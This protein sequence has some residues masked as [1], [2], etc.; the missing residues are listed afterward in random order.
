MAQGIGG[1]VKQNAAVGG[2]LGVGLGA[3]EIAG[4]ESKL[5]G[6]ASVLAGILTWKAGLAALF[7]GTF[8]KSK[9]AMSNLIKESGS[10]EAALRRIG[11]AAEDAG[12]AYAKAKDKMKAGAGAAW[13]ESEITNTKNMTRAVE[14]MTPAVTAASNEWAKISGGLST[15]KS[16]MTKAAAE[17]GVLGSAIN[18]VSQS[19]GALAIGLSAIAGVALVKWLFELSSAAGASA[20]WIF[21]MEAATSGAVS[22]LAKF[23]YY[24]LRVVQVLARW[25]GIGIIVSGILAVGGAIHSQIKAWD[26]AGKAANRMLDAALDSTRAIAAQISMIKTAEDQAKA[27]ASALDEL[28]KAQQQ[29]LAVKSSGKSKDSQ[30]MQAAETAKVMAEKAVKRAAAATPTEG[31]GSGTEPA[32]L[33]ARIARAQSDAALEDR[34]ANASEEAKPDLLREKARIAAERAATGASEV[35]GRSGIQMRLDEISREEA[36]NSGKEGTVKQRERDA[37]IAE[38]ESNQ[39][40]GYFPKDQT[41]EA[42]IAAQE[43]KVKEHGEIKALRDARD[44]GEDKYNPETYTDERIKALKGGSEA[45]KLE[46]RNME[47]QKYRR[48]GEGA[49]G[50]QEEISRN[51]VRIDELRELAGN[52]SGNAVGAQAGTAEAGRGDLRVSEAKALLDIEA[53]IAKAKEEGYEMSVKEAQA[54]REQLYIQ[55]AYAAAKHGADSQEVKQAQVKIDQIDK[56]GAIRKRE[57]ESEMRQNQASLDTSTI[58]GEGYEVEKQKD[59][60]ERKRLAAEEAAAVGDEAKMKAKAAREA[61]DTMRSGKEVA[62]YESEG[63]LNSEFFRSGAQALGDSAAVTGIDDFEE[64]RKNFDARKGVMGLDTA[65]DDAMFIA[66]NA[67]TL[68][69]RNDMNSSNAGVASASMARIGGGG[70]IG[71]GATSMIDLQKRTNDLLERADEHLEIIK[72][73][74]DG[75]PAN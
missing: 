64:F 17:S 57:H 58:R 31:P 19:V 51:A 60:I 47:I 5:K 32:V 13:A 30:E 59:A 68:Q 14:A 75:I 4:A 39:V 3:V 10:L 52:S 8:T 63:A 33:A 72:N 48:T 74:R 12:T 37:R 40:R 36:A 65:K 20:K 6:I 15:A 16:E 23:Q 49:A 73:K 61:H 25:G 41:R 27:Y 21:K 35:S 38:I 24:A 54:Q 62:Q 56:A 11:K 53:D 7:V 70:G 71:P 18:V 34:I 66:K 69:A 44:R 29:W 26:E 1:F 42:I 43:Q 67:I 22:G 45:D 46:A 50:T 55:M 2:A 28:T 9:D